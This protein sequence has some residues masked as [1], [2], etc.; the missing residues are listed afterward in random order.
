M[1]RTP[2]PSDDAAARRLATL[3]KIRIVLRTAQQHSAWVEKQCGV[4]GAQ[5]WIL[6]ELAD[7]G[8]MRV[9]ALARTLAI[10]QTTTSNLLD[11]LDKRGLVAKQRDPD[12]QRAVLV[13]LT[14]A[15]AAL[16]AAA[17]KPAR[18]LLATALRQMPE[19]ELARLDAGLQQLLA[20]I[21]ALDDES[22]LQ[23]LPFM[24]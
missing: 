16:L 10:H 9:G 17:P 22:G 18:G 11:E 15:G 5:L 3:Q 13:S 19:G 4:S 23:P 2:T 20:A 24:M 6:A 21:G 12:D 14:T 7:Q 8:G 1:T